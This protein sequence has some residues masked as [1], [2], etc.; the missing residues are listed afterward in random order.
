MRVQAKPALAAM[1]VATVVVLGASTP[2]VAET[3]PGP[4]TYELTVGDASVRVPRCIG[5]GT[6]SEVIESKT[7]D[8]N[9]QVVIRKL[10]GASK[11]HD[12]VCTRAMTDDDTFVEWQRQLMEG[13]PGG[14]QDVDL[15]LFD[16]TLAEFAR[17]RYVS[18]WPSELTYLDSSETGGPLLEV[19]TIVADR[20]ERVS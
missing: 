16:A 10:P 8:P 1:A 17:F 13:G 18:A 15:V 20:L 19:V 4:I 14:R 11:H 2:S 7:T 12:L 3:T 9:G 5:I 6:A